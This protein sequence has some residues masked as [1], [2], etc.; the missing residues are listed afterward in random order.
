M[1]YNPVKDVLEGIVR[2]K[3][4]D[5]TLGESEW[6]DETFPDHD[7][8]IEYRPI[9]STETLY[10]EDKERGIR[11]NIEQR[12]FIMVTA[13]DKRV[14][15]MRGELHGA[16]GHSNGNKEHFRI[17]DDSELEDS[18]RNT[19]KYVSGLMMLP[20]AVQCVKMDPH[21]LNVAR[22]LGGL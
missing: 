10:I 22:D 1:E 19:V 2:L 18:I 9:G 12:T 16:I 15:R 11:V 13:Y 4:L 6:I 8:K 20:D 7:L 3:G 5:L 17:N 21:S 14:E